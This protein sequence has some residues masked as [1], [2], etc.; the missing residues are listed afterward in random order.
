MADWAANLPLDSATHRAIN[1]HWQRSLEVDLLREVEHDLRVIAWM[2]T[3]DGGRGRNFP[4]RLELPWDP[5]PE[6][7]RGDAYDWSDLADALGGDQRLIEFMAR[8]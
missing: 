7:I 1:P 4:E 8:N 2:E 3:K 6:S 5:K